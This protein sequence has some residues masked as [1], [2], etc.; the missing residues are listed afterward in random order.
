MVY[1][2]CVTIYPESTRD[3]FGQQ[4]WASGVEMKARTMEEN[5]QVLSL[6]NEIT[7]SDLTVHIPIAYSQYGVVGEKLVH[8][9]INYIVLKAKLPKNEV[10]HVVDV[11]LLCKRNG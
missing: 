10:G 8:N 4:V 11:N 2:D 3:A 9:G 1:N 7:Q 6:K 5:R